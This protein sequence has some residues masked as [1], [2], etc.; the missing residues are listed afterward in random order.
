MKLFDWQRIRWRFWILL[1]LY[2]FV[3]GYLGLIF[4]SHEGDVKLVT[5]FYCGLIFAVIV[6]MIV[7][8]LSSGSRRVK[9]DPPALPR[10]MPPCE[11]QEKFRPSEGEIA[12]DESISA[13]HE[14]GWRATKPRASG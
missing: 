4:G 2:L 10:V 5:C 3:G 13:V 1:P 14:S 11:E 8:L 12:A 7:E 9:G 6:G